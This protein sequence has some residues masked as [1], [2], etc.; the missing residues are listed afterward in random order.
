MAPGSTLGR[1]ELGETIGQGGVAEV[2]R[3][4]ARGAG[5]F[6]KDVVIKRIRDDLKGD[7]DVRAAFARE[8]ALS[9]RLGHGNIVQTLDVGEDD[10]GAPYLVLELVDGCTLQAVL[11]DHGDARPSRALALFVVEQIAAALHYVHEARDAEGHA[12]GLVH[13]DVTPANILL[14]R[15]GV[16]KLA[17]F[18]IA[19]SAA[20]GSDTLPGFIKGTV[21]YLA[22]EQAAGRPVDRR[23]D[24]YALGLVLRRMLVGDAQMDALEP[25]LRAIVEHAT[26]PAVRDRTASASALQSEVAAWRVAAKTRDGVAAVKEAV[27]QQRGDR[28]ARSLSLD[29]ALGVSPR[30]TRQVAPAIAREPVRT[31]MPRLAIASLAAAIVLAVAWWAWLRP[32]VVEVT[33][34]TAARDEVPPSAMP[35]IERAQ[36]PDDTPVDDETPRD[37]GPGIEPAADPATAEAPVETARDPKSRPK[38]RLLVN[39]VP[40]AEVTVDGRA[41][42]RTPVDRE[43]RAGKHTV[44]LYNPDTGRRTTKRVTT[45]PDAPLRITSW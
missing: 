31:A 33:T 16:V 4:R 26:E 8:A 45:S 40:Y 19:R 24:V 22:P 6:A 23:A 1:Y 42:G 43:V 9:Q 18:G 13:R 15:D 11:D 29:A 34:P 21:Q 38:S 7:H 27:A 3:A 35:E 39:V 10:D 12:M 5:G 36:A 25:E 44:E 37:V 17:D 30:A 14:G 2:V 20:M 28:V 32:E 41:L